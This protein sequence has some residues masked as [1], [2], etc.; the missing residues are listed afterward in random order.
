VYPSASSRGIIESDFAAAEA[1]DKAVAKVMSAAR[2][3]LA[4][5]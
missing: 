5:A 4:L 1:I 2:D 3:G